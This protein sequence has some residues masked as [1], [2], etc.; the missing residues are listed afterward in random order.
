MALAERVTVVADAAITAKGAKH[1]HAVRVEVHLRDGRRLER[2]EETPHGSDQNFAG[3]DDIVGKFEKLAAHALPARRVGEL[4]DA[5]LKLDELRNA[6]ELA[7]LM[8]A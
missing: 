5:V 2:S 4:R 1:R 6:G 7:A 8:S 3:A